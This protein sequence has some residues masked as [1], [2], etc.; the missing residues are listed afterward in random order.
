MDIMDARER[1][2]MFAVMMAMDGGLPPHF[3]I[4][5]SSNF[6]NIYQTFQTKLL[7]QVPRPMRTYYLSNEVFMGRGT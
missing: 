4:I 1:Y 6:A 2:G 3:D 5:I 7:L